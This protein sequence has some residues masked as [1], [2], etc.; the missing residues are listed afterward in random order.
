MGDTFS[1][2]GVISDYQQWG[3]QK[4]AGEYV[5]MNR[6]IDFRRYVIKLNVAD[7]DNILSTI[8]DNYE[9]LF[10]EA[11]F[12]H[13]FIDEQFAQQYEAD[14][15]F[16]Q[17]ISLF[18]GLAIFIACLGLL[19]LSLFM[20]LQ[21]RKEIGVRK[22]LGASTTGIIQ[23]LSKDF[24][25]LVILALV[26][27]APIASYFLDDWLANYA[28]RIAL[29]CWIFIAAGFGTILLAFMTISIQSLKAAL[30]NPIQALRSE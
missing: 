14:N 15:R 19:G 9:S 29:Q 2:V 24:L 28:H 30:A 25:K 26:I 22:V 23:L 13:Y 8:Q 1:V 27:A 6:P 4:A 5:F 16:S 21:R 17:I 3:L 12:E 10:P 18:A 7:L 20:I 11:V